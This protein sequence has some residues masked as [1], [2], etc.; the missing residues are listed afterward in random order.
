[1]RITPL[2]AIGFVLLLSLPLALHAGQTNI[3]GPS[4]SGRF[5]TLVTVL[6]NG[7]FVVVDPTYDAPG[8]IVD[9]GAVYLYS[10]AGVLISTLTGTTANDHVG[11][12]EEDLGM[13]TSYKGAITVLSNGNYVVM[14]RDW[15]NGVQANAGAVT[16]CSATTGAGVSA[17]VSP[18]NSLV[19]AVSEDRV[20][21][22]Q[23]QPGVFPLPNG[24]YV[25]LSPQ[26]NNG[27]AVDAGAV[28]LC[29]GTTGIP[30]GSLATGLVSSLNSLVGSTSSDSVGAFG[31]VVLTNGNF[32]VLNSLWDNTS[33]AAVNAGAVTWISAAA[34][35]TGAVSSSNSLVGTSDNDF[36]GNSGIFALSNGHFVVCSSGWNDGMWDNVGA[37]T[38][39]DGVFGING[40]VHQMNSL[41]GTSENDFVGSGGAKALPNGNYVVRSPGWNNQDYWGVIGAGAVT[42]RNGSASAPGIVT[43]ANSLVGTTENSAVGSWV[44]VVLT[45]GNY[46]VHSPQWSEGVIFFQGAV[47]WG[48]GTTGV[49]GPVSAANSLVG[50]SES[51]SVGAFPSI[52]LP[53][54]NYVVR[55]PNWTDGDKFEVGAITWGSGTSGVKG[56]I[57]AANSLI[58]GTENDSIG[59]TAVVALTNGHYVVASSQWHNGAP[60]A[61]GAVTWCN[62]TTGTRGVV[63]AFNSLVGNAGD[64]VGNAGVCALT[65]GNYVVG[66][67]SWSGS[68]GAVVWANGSS[69]I[70]GTIS[71]ANAL[72]GSVSGD[73][74]GS[75]GIIPLANGNYVVVSPVCDNG[76]IEAAGAVTWGNGTT[77][78]TGPVSSVN[79]LVGT[80]AG[81]QVGS[82][83]FS[84]HITTHAD[85]NYTVHS[86]YWQNTGLP[87]AGAVTLGLGNGGTVGAVSSANSVLGT[88]A[89]DDGMMMMGA[90]SGGFV[91][92]HSYDPAKSQL[93]VGRPDSNIVTRFSY[94][95][96]VNLSTSLYTV[97][98]EAG[99]VDIIVTR[100]NG[101][102]GAASVNIS[103]A[104]GTATAGGGGDYLP[105]AVTPVNFAAGE[106]SQTVNIGILPGNAVNEP[107]ETF[108]INLTS[109]VGV[110]LGAV[111]AA[112]VQI[113]DPGDVTAPS[114]PVITV[115]AAGALVGANSGGPLTVSGTATDGK[116]IASV[117]V[118]LN[119]GPFVPATLT[120]ATATTVNWSL[121]V[122]P[123]TGDGDAFAGVATVGAAFVIVM[124][125]V[126]E[127]A[128]LVARILAEPEVAGAVYSPLLL[129][130][131]EP[132]AI[133]QVMPGLNVSASPN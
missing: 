50:T 82:N 4:G 111:A 45:N 110:S 85:G 79:S 59:Q 25:V 81:D 100:S 129:I 103:T 8:P 69:G 83:P 99:G 115:P 112:T 91:L 65:N 11:G 132:E 114:A 16:F 29:N 38:W 37:V 72:V 33:P 70:T 84:T 117:E 6:P 51:D 56:P 74:V 14:S 52:P 93:V 18:T 23:G 60:A 26:W 24:N 63:S 57:S 13:S 17:V 27:G 58:G 87:N 122:V 75:S 119:G 53:N 42:W 67:S 90:P 78:T 97:N 19:G 48:S 130:E 34:G 133:A 120:N 41:V 73:S 49:S 22:V 127:I 30:V 54:G 76:A 35:I 94:G 46:V 104:P 2:S 77:G 131:P 95:G 40:T 28:T 61:A 71:A 125:A 66:A 20:G 113:I 7:N 15:D 12:F 9:V 89:G 105:L 36:V 116:G 98:E 31:I 32:V 55:T 43:P 118:Q 1:M 80:T 68:R 10:S 39:G 109:P 107:N 123:V 47:T 62:G 64:G 96:V 92:S 3:N 86:P 128:L 5:G 108:F 88:I 121:A 101:S 102:F 106:T 44:T 124:A 126:V 21:L